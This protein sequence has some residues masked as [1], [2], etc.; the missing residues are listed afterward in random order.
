MPLGLIWIYI[1]REMLQFAKENDGVVHEIADRY[2]T[3]RF[4]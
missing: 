4:F 1:C 3:N 2:A